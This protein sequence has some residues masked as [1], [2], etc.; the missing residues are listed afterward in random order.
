MAL[1]MICVRLKSCYGKN[2][3]IL[4]DYSFSIQGFGG[5]ER[6]FISFQKI[7]HKNNTG[8]KSLIAFSTNLLFYFFKN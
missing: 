3:S 5:H 1:K 4:S 8:W 2:I 6:G 7:I